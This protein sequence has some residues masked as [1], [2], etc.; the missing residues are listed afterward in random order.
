MPYKVIQVKLTG[1]QV[2]EIEKSIGLNVDASE[3]ALLA[4]PKLDREVLNVQVISK[5]QYEIVRPAILEAY[6]LPPWKR[7]KS[8]SRKET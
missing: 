6:K 4:E 5:E 8:K 1:A 7:G 2:M 3:Y